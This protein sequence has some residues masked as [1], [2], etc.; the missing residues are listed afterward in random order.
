MTTD[1]LEMDTSNTLSPRM[2]KRLR[3]RKLIPQVSCAVYQGPRAK[4][5]TEPP[6]E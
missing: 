3:G 5:V 2:M 6:V 1:V 4:P